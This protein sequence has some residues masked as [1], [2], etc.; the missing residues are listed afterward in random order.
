MK[1]P[2]L[3]STLVIVDNFSKKK[4]KHGPFNGL[5]VTKLKMIEG[6]CLSS[7]CPIC[8]GCPVPKNTK[9]NL[10]FGNFHHLSKKKGKIALLMVY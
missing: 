6:Q 8:E 3:T 9:T 10:Y 5:L 1:I 4:G 2:E 7:F